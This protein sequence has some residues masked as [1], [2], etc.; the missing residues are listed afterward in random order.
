MNIKELCHN[1]LDMDLRIMVLDEDL[2]KKDD[3]IGSVDLSLRDAIF[4]RGP[5]STV[6]SALVSP[7]IKKFILFMVISYH[8]HT[9]MAKK[10]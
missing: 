6:F 2:A 9:K 7:K 1:N 8:I 4:K 3:F 10:Y 5:F